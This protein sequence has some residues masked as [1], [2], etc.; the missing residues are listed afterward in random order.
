MHFLTEAVAR[1]LPSESQRILTQIG[2]MRAECRQSKKCYL[3]FVKVPPLAAPSEQTNL[4]F[5]FAV[6]VSFL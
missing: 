5:M 2:W 4:Q 6:N 1:T 3:I